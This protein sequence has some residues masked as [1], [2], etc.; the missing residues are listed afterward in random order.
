MLEIT[1]MRANWF[2]CR[3]ASR[4]QNKILRT[5]KALDSYIVRK[6]THEHVRHTRAMFQTYPNLSPS[7]LEYARKVLDISQGIAHL[8]MGAERRN[9]SANIRVCSRQVKQEHL[10]EVVGFKRSKRKYVPSPLSNR[11]LSE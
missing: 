4:Q 8:D 11:F 7:T 10:L 6:I 1:H 3:Q 5:R 2:H 9:L